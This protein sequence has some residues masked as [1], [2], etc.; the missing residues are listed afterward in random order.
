MTRSGEGEAQPPPPPPSL[1]QLSPPPG[2][3]THTRTDSL[4]MSLRV[5]L[6]CNQGDKQG[7]DGWSPAWGPACP[8]PPHPPHIAHLSGFVQREAD[9]DGGDE[10]DAQGVPVVVVGQPQPDA[11]GLEPIVGVQC[12]GG[13]EAVSGP[14]FPGQPSHREQSALRRSQDH[15]QALVSPIRRPSS[16]SFF[17]ALHRTWAFACRAPE[18]HFV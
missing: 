7:V 2:R 10:E 17:F 8:A 5:W 3:H 4:T 16:P 13:Q 11:E 14:R 15:S 1:P 18:K 6:C 12:L 9:G